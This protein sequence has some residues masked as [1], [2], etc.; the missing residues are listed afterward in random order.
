VKE[1]LLFQILSLVAYIEKQ[2][3]STFI[4][5]GEET[6]HLPVPLTDLDK[7]L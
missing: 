3:I 4:I 5:P 6:S 7:A 2:R 1:C